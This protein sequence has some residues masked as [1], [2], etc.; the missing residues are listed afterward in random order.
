MT[1]KKK[2]Q[3]ILKLGQ[4]LFIKVHL[5][6]DSTLSVHPNQNSAVFIPIAALR[7]H[8]HSDRRS[9]VSLQTGAQIQHVQHLIR[10]SISGR[11]HMSVFFT[12]VQ[13]CSLDLIRN[14]TPAFNRPSGVSV[15]RPH[16]PMFVLPHRVFWIYSRKTASLQTPEAWRC[17][18]GH[19]AANELL[20]WCVLHHNG[21]SVSP[22]PPAGTHSWWHR[23]RAGSCQAFSCAHTSNR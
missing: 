19:P 22:L 1:K 3:A 18:R 11:F 10:T 7:V 9:A 13:M 20:C 2:K 14:T 21:S 15:C 12:A 17:G 23:A 8:F 5:E 16:Q 6:A 4:K